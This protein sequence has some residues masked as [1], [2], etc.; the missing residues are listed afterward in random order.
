M[1][2]VERV[3]PLVPADRLRVLT[4]MALA[5]PIL[6]AAPLLTPSQLLLEPVARGTAPVLTWAAHAIAAVD[7]AAVMLS[8]HSDHVVE[9]ASAFRGSLARAA[10][11][12]S[13]HERLF[14]LGA[15]P[16]RPETG[17]GYITPG[18]ALTEDGAACAVARFVEKPDIASAERY[19]AEGCLWNTGIF[20]WPVR[21]LLEQVR[22]HTPELASLLPLLD[23]G[24]VEG[25]F[26][27]APALSIDEG[28]LERSDRVA[29]LRADFRWDDV[30]AW[31]AVGRN[32]ERDAAGNAGIGDT[33]FV[34]AHD[35]VAWADDGSIVVFGASDL[36]VV[37]SGGITFVAPRARTPELKVLLEQL[38]S[39]LLNG[40][41]GTG[42][43]SG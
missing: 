24:D 19:I 33:H 34:D 38:P 21:L 20:V 31:D 35:C 10:D 8:L 39:R 17:Y 27:R 11:L 14:T 9:P 25:F 43:G 7:P 5:E 3:L 16:S 30:G 29:V 37:R 40:E 41:P 4:G 2:T 13:R 23:V 22:Q 28:L 1:Q 18:D 12:A 26:D 6:E 15:V 32:H 36:V 42:S